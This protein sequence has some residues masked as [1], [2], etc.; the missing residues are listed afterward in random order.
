MTRFIRLSNII[1]NTSKI[2]QI[3]TSPQR[4]TI[5]MCNNHVSGYVIGPVGMI[6]TQDNTIQIWKDKNE[7]DY[8]IITDWIKYI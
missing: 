3:H 2:V 5:Y 7:T 4:Y 1:I 8:K 6:N